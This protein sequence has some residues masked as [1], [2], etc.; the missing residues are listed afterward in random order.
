MIKILFV[1]H[2]NICRSTMAEFL[3]KDI[4]KKEK[5]DN[6][7]YIESAGTSSEEEGNPVYF[8]TQKILN[9]LNID[10]SNKRARKIKMEDYSYF[11]YIIGMD[12]HNRIN[13]LR[14]YNYDP[15]KKINLL[16]DFTDNP[17]DVIDP[18]YYGNFDKTYSDI[19]EGLNALLNY[20]KTKHNLFE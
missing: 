16:L 6:L 13:L 2:G 15:L 8:E 20:L 18:W 11:D 7:I 14:F 5:L 4:V 9:N 19:M 12:E 17:R 3:F 10:C 1:C